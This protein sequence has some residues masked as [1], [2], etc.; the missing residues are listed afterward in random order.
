MKHLHAIA[1]LLCTASTAHAQT[2]VRAD[3]A[4][5]KPGPAAT[6]TGTVTVRMTAEAIAPGQA[7]AAV[8]SFQP[9]ARTNWHTH[10]AG[11]ILYVTQGCGWVQEEGS[12]VTRICTGDTIHS[13]P[14]TRHWHGA[15]DKEGM[16]HLAVTEMVAGK[17]V[18]WLE[19]VTAAQYHG[20]GR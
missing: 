1:L 14:G 3:E 2:I 15:T 11:Q 17:A 8:V 19:P 9:G 20:P 7:G 12:P 4:P 18:D 5:A 6:F 13:A 10:P 16:R